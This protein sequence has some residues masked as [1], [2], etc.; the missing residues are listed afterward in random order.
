[1]KAVRSLGTMAV[2]LERAIELD[3]SLDKDATLKGV[4]D[5]GAL[6][7]AGPDAPKSLSAKRRK[8]KGK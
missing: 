2:L 1:M 6:G 7:K 3:P 8:K 4:L 5:S